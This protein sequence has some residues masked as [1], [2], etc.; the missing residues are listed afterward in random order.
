MKKRRHVGLVCFVSMPLALHAQER[1][2][3]VEDLMAIDVGA[4]RKVSSP[5]NGVD[6]VCVLQ[7]YQDRVF[8][9]F[10]GQDKVN[11]TLE[12]IGYQGDE[13]SWAVLSI[14]GSHV[15]MLRVGRSR[16][17]DLLNEHEGNHL[18]LPAGFEPRACADGSHAAFSKVRYRDRLYVILGNSSE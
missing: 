18:A 10:E 11:A 6:M 15:D 12:A 7:P 16:N 3:Q 5:E 17:L 1:R 4:V 9:A 8:F 13:G 2:L 14:T